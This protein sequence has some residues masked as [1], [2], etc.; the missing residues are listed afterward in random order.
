M[1]RID[2]AGVSRLK[3]IGN[4][5]VCAVF[6]CCLFVFSVF[7]F[8]VEKKDHSDFENRDMAEFPVLWDGKSVNSDFYAE[9]DSYYSDAFPFRDQFL[10]AN[11]YIQTLY[12][13]LTLPGEDD[14]VVFIAAAGGA[15]AVDVK[16]GN[17]GALDFDADVFWSE[18][19]TRSDVG[20]GTGASGY[21]G[22]GIGDAA[23]SDTA[24]EL[25]D[26]ADLADAADLE[27]AAGRG[28]DMKDAGGLDGAAAGDRSDNVNGEAG[29]TGS[30]SNAGGTGGANGTNGAG[31][32]AATTTLKYAHNNVAT[33]SGADA[34]G[35]SGGE[36][37]ATGVTNVSGASYTSGESG[38]TD[39]S[40]ATGAASAG[41]GETP[42]EALGESPGATLAG[43]SDGG[44]SP[45]AAETGS[46]GGGEASSNGETQAAAGDGGGET[47]PAA[48]SPPRA[49]QNAQARNA[50]DA[51]EY[52]ANE[53]TGVSIV[54]GQA[55][56]VFIFSE[57]R[58]I[59]FAETVDAI[60]ESCGVPT[61]V[62]IPPSAS[63]L[64]LP[65]KYRGLQN[66]QKPAFNL[67]A[68]T[69]KNAVLVD[70]YDSFK[71]EKDNYIYF[72]TDH[73]WTADGAFLAYREFAKAAGF[74]PVYRSS[75]NRGRLDGFLGSLYRQIYA[76]RNSLL[77]EQEPDYVRYYEPIYE[78]E[79]I[80]FRDADMKEGIQG[81]V[82]APE[83]DLGQNL[84]NV[85][86]G[87]DM[88]LLYMHS[89]VANGR[90]IIAVRDSYGHAFLPYL[91]NNYEHVY[92]VE[93]RYFESFPLAQF[94]ADHKIDEL[95][96]VNHSLLATARY[97]MNWITELEKLY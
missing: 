2:S 32:A 75:M 27:G 28:N 10:A 12:T 60:A 59:A 14:G 42:G 92:A 68:A 74:S 11:R 47:S 20:D 83:G 88:H 49:L 58:T 72:L 51:A 9:L 62:V 30:A 79:V 18:G 69:M 25:S 24:A 95:V 40:G 17:I 61:Y 78:T 21:N 80:N 70:L 65:E 85:F 31:S 56:E 82:L 96:F 5:A 26:A 73:H 13:A 54:S 84:Y 71:T 33:T 87:G 37:G 52:E 41:P 48:D 53:S 91:A 77:L 1:L 22:G 38:V 35:A 8:V 23:R 46:P 55:F 66:E 67:L 57:S 19:F 97:W 93:P 94:I 36:S 39:S 4:I 45:S 64:Y 44:I 3:N 6:I 7:F 76:D 86:F 16:A 90:S 89:G 34:S 50:R 29:G 15:G 43:E 81:A 63:E